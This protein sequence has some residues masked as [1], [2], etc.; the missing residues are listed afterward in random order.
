MTNPWSG[1]L[2]YKRW[3]VSC[4]RLQPSCGIWRSSYPK[5]LKLNLHNPPAANLL[6]FY[7]AYLSYLDVN[8]CQ[9]NKLE[10]LQNVCIRFIFGC[11]N[12]ITFL[13]FVLSLC[14]F[15]FA[16]IGIHIY[17]LFYTLFN[18]KTPV[19]LRDRFKYLHLNNTHYLRSSDNMRLE[20][21]I[22]PTNFSNRSLTVHAL[23][24]WNASPYFYK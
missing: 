5:T 16:F 21:P 11:A 10:W 2:N 13:N 12:I 22:S 24:R 18:P 4:L 7:Q 17:C 19:Y 1:P 23:C 20:T 9:L 14:G 3:V 8:V 15:P 6:H